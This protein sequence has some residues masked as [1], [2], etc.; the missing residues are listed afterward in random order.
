MTHVSMSK[1]PAVTFLK[2]KK[3]SLAQ[4]VKDPALSLPQPSS[5][6]RRGFDLWPGS[7]HMPQVRPKKKKRKSK[8]TQ[9]KLS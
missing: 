3:R 4:P 1:L 9:I 8:K 6:L 2:R 5:L 7:F